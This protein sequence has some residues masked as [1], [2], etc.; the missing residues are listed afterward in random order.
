[1]YPQK[2]P[3]SIHK[4]RS[5]VMVGFGGSGGIV[6]AVEG[7]WVAFVRCGR[8]PSLLVCC[9]LSFSSVGMLYVRV[10]VREREGEREN[11][12]VCVAHKLSLSHTPGGPIEY[13]NTHTHTHSFS[14]SLS[15]SLSHT[16]ICRTKWSYQAHKFQHVHILSHTHTHILTNTLTHQVDLSNTQIGDSGVRYV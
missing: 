6:G 11:V 13:A 9:C 5:W 2:S 16:H 15:L 12:C 7:A 8:Y 1:M 14:L 10:C 3:I 4:I